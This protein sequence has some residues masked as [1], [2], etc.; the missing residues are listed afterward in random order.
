MIVDGRHALNLKL[1]KRQTLLEP[2]ESFDDWQEII[3]QYGY[4]V[5]FASVFPM[6][7]LLSWL[8]NEIER[9][10]DLFKLKYV[11]QRPIPR[12][13]LGP[14]TNILHAITLMAVL[15]NSAL[16]SISSDQLSSI[17]LVL[18]D[19]KIDDSGA[20]FLP[21]M[22]KWAVAICFLI[23]HVLGGAVLLMWHIVQSMPESIKNS[24]AREAYVALKTAD[25]NEDMFVNNSEQVAIRSV[26][27]QKELTQSNGFHPAVAGAI[28]RKLWK[29]KVS[30]R[31][32]K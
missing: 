13:V 8:A 27:E 25:D 24:L 5:L 10:H 2:Y 20:H 3:I 6:G 12:K 4:I 18:T 14:W 19:N 26:V 22:G 21:G 23:E 31:E 29:K 15:T 28:R 30:L 11:S 32:K 16:V 1:G 9:H 17:G 7:P